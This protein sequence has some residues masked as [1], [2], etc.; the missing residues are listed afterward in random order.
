MMRFL[1]DL[2]ETHKIC[3]KERQGAN[4]LSLIRVSPVVLLLRSL[5]KDIS[6][7]DVETTVLYLIKE[8][9]TS[10]S[11]SLSIRVKKQV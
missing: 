10:I 5:P 11:C 3:Q 6:S 8:I 9:D 1:S 2:R 4:F 7:I